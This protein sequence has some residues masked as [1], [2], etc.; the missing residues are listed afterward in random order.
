MSNIVFPTD[1]YGQR[2]V[3]KRIYLEQDAV[4]PERFF[5]LPELFALRLQM[6]DQKPI[7]RFAG[8]SLSFRGE[9]YSTGYLLTVS[10]NQADEKG[11]FL[12]DPYAKAFEA[13]ERSTERL[14]DSPYFLLT[15]KRRL[16][17]RQ[18]EESHSSA[19]AL[20]SDLSAFGSRPKLNRT[21]VEAMTY[22]EVEQTLSALSKSTTG[23]YL[24]LG[25][26]DG[27]KDPL[28]K[29]KSLTTGLDRLA[30]SFALQAKD[31][32]GPFHDET[33]DYVFSV[34]EVK[35][36]QDVSALGVF[37]SA[38]GEAVKRNLKQNF[39]LDAKISFRLL[40]RIRTLFSVTV[41]PHQLSMAE[42]ALD[43][44][45]KNGTTMSIQDF[46]EEG[47]L[48]KKLDSVRLASSFPLAVERLLLVS[49]LG[50]S[51]DRESFFTV[52]VPS[53][54]AVVG[55]SKQVDPLFHVSAYAGEKKA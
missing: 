22:E 29:A 28:K 32:F 17:F 21:L 31:L 10:L 2:E 8:A 4:S 23:S 5:I 19:L 47:R 45:L 20:L 40:S 11:P 44:W 34:P 54:E 37:F 9:T 3:L 26:A 50:L 15:A 51:F 55:L 39:N 12:S 30:S 27:K 49:D 25:P 46:L 16:L 36:L 13:M 6:E 24:Y 1:S 7:E 38:L 42:T 14:P 18:E 35:N 41:R 43:E 52:P 48:E 53:A 33:R